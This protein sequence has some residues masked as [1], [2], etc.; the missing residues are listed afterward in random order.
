MADMLDFTQALA[1]L[2]M[3]E[4]ELQDLIAKGELRAFRSGGTMKFKKG[5]V[6][7]LKSERATE[8]TII[9]P[10]A[11]S[12]A[13]LNM[14]VP[15]DLGVDESAATVVP[16][17]SPGGSAP[18]VDLGGGQSGTEEIVFED[19][20][21]QI[22]PLDGDASAAEVTVAAEEP[23]SMPM[24]DIEI[25]DD[26]ELEDDRPRRS[27]RRTSER[28]SFSSR[29]QQAAFAKEPGNPA[30]TGMLVVTALLFVFVASVFT[31]MLWKGY[32]NTKKKATYVP[33]P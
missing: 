20:D 29:R 13:A 25:D 15:Q 16:D 2:Q 24:D 28:G 26:E 6:D 9:I 27:S 32:Y 7:A 18:T 5:D 1:E 21:L 22:L 14:D 10:A 11:G 23:L 33:L 4:A 3:S 19:S 8:P 30:V 17:I 12:G 31:V